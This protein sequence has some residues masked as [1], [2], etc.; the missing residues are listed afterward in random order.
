MQTE[1]RQ[2]LSSSHDW[3]SGVILYQQHG[4]DAALLQRFQRGETPNAKK[5]LFYAL[6]GLIVPQN[7]AE[8]PTR[9]LAK[10]V[11]AEAAIVSPEKLEENPA[12]LAA[13]RDADRAFKEL[14][15]T[16]ALL[17]AICDVE[18]CPD[19]RNA[20]KKRERG[21]L[22]RSIMHQQ[23]LVDEAYE[24][25]RF[26]LAHKQRRA[27][28]VAVIEEIAPEKLYQAITNL[29]KYISKLKR[30]EQGKDVTAKIKIKENLLKHYLKQYDVGKS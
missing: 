2:W 4:R 30:G 18:E 12:S 14:Q 9:S 22:A 13:K 28:P 5:A 6:K 16:R 3:E 17:L 19:D 23:A 15:N 8:K 27:A 25:Y 29:R 7:Q 24:D 10:H 11:V 20:D 21:R 26:A 1:I